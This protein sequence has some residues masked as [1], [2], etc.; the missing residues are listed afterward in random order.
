MT[1]CI[2]TG[3]PLAAAKLSRRVACPVTLIH[4]D[5]GTVVPSEVQRFLDGH[6]QTRVVHV[7]GATHFL[8]MERPDIVQQELHLLADHLRPQ[9]LGEP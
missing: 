4:G 9:P 2:T 3:A 5:K 8:P 1:P 6:P 7:P